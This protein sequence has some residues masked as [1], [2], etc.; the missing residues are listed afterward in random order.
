MKLWS[1]NKMEGFTN[2]G[3]IKYIKNI[4]HRHLPA[5]CWDERYVP[6]A[7]LGHFLKETP[8]GCPMKCWN[9]SQQLFSTSTPLPSSAFPRRLSPSPYCTLDFVFF[10]VCIF[11]PVW[12]RGSNKFKSLRILFYS[13]FSFCFMLFF[14]NHSPIYHLK[15]NLLPSL[16]WKIDTSFNLFSD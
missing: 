13:L 4:G 10:I 11:P 2:M 8:P 1:P 15:K 16:V 14:W 3:R 7:D 9:L 6:S 12:I 5:I